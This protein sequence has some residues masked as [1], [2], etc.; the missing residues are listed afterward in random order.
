MINGTSVRLCIVTVLIGLTYWGANWVQASLEP[1]GADM[2]DWTFH[3]LPIRLG[4]WVGEDTTMDPRIAVKTGAKIIVDRA[5]HDDSGHVISMHTAVSDNPNGVLHSPLVCYQA[6]GWVKLS[7]SR[8]VLQLHLSDKSE[9][10]LPVS[11]SK[12]ENEKDSRKVMVVYWFQLGDHFLF[13][14]WDLGMKIRWSLAGRKK[15]PVLIK[16]MMEIPI[17]EG[18]DVQSTALAFVEQVAAWENQPAHRN[19]KGMVGVRSGGSG[20]SATANP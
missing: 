2:P 10:P 11:V 1:P 20:G 17:V 13:G 19:G 5:Y 8:K 15:W 9:L 4:D 12:W 18:E 14:R 6:A 7:E 3:D 16:V